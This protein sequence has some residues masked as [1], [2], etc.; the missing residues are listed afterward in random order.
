MEPVKY[1]CKRLK[2]M[3]WKKFM[4]NFTLPATPEVDRNEVDPNEEDPNEEDS[5]DD[6]SHL[7]IIERKVKKWTLSKMALQFN[8]WKKR[9]YKEFINKEKTPV[10]TG[11]YEKI[12]DHWDAFVECKTL[13][14]AKRRS[15]INKKNGAK[16]K[17]QY[18]G[19]RLLQVWQA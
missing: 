12:K 18:Y 14:A 6:D 15:E 4:V 2:N 9:L 3:L 10:F 13:E 5:D 16:K 11:Q 1:V 17:Y 19:A 8:N 7:N